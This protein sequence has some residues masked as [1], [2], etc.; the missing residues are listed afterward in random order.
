MVLPGLTYIRSQTYK[1]AINHTAYYSLVFYRKTKK[2]DDLIFLKKKIF[3]ITNSKY[4]FRYK[5][6]REYIK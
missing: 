4:K 6:Q 5:L 3:S 2:D 1:Y